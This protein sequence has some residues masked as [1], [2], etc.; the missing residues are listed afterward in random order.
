LPASTWAMMPILRISVRG[1]VRAIAKFRRFQVKRFGEALGPDQ[2][3]GILP[4]RLGSV[5]E[6]YFEDAQPIF[7]D[8]GARSRPKCAI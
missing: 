4:R 2:K 3:P 6:P 5:E 8:G 1:V 7:K